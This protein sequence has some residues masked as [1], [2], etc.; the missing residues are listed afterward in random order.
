M[1]VKASSKFIRISPKKVRLVATLVRGL[2]VDEAIVQLQ[3]SK[4][5]AALPIG[6]L[7]KSAIANAEEN[8]DLK[9][10]NLF[11][12]EIFVDEG[13]TIKRWFP[14]AMGRATP[15]RKRSSH[16]NLVLSEKVPTV[17]KEK[18]KE[19]TK[20]DIVNIDDLG[21]VGQDNKKASKAQDTKDVKSTADNSKK[22]VGKI[23]NRTGNK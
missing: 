21:K 23:F 11:V 3:F 15:K 16:I 17:K 8:D 12:S 9:R 13:P 20:D 18:K 2:E 7:I 6:K 4:K 1:E 22:S 10:D 5:D 14:R 19:D